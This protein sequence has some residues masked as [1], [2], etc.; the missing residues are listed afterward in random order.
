MYLSLP[1]VRIILV[2]LS[3]VPVKK[4]SSRVFFATSL[5]SSN[6]F[7]FLRLVRSY[8]NAFVTMVV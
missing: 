3:E 1:A 7:S 8:V 6:T 2:S 4:K 5:D